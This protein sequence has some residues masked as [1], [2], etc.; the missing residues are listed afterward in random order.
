MSKEP[1]LPSSTKHQ[2]LRISGALVGSVSLDTVWGY[3]LASFDNQQA[4]VGARDSLNGLHKRIVWTDPPRE[5]VRGLSRTL[6]EKNFLSPDR[7]KSILGDLMDAPGHQYVNR[8]N[9][10]KTSYSKAEIDDI[11]TDGEQRAYFS[12]VPTPRQA[13]SKIM[14]H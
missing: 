8:F 6:T 14:R 11:W 10:L 13:I 9:Q 4:D 12:R 7:K 2:I 5:E 1:M 3:T